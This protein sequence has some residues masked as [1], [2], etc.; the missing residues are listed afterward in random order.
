MRRAFTLVE[1]LVALAIFALSSVV[2]GTAYVNVLN[3]YERARIAGRKDIEVQAARATLLAEA[4]IKK[5]REGG[6]FESGEKRKLTWKA[7]IEPTAT[8]DLFRVEFECEF[9]SFDQRKPE[10]VRETFQVLRP[11]W[12][13]AADRDKLRAE[14]RKRIDTLNARQK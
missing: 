10:I 13:E 8:T 5:A 9:T 11:T 12:S 7:T 14:A 1:V 3:G 2:L 6:D 4:D